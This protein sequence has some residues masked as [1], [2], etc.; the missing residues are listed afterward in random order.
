MLTTSSPHNPQANGQAESGVAIAERILRQNDPVKALMVYRATP[1]VSTGHSPS[2]LMM[3][4]EMSTTLPILS[5][6]LAPHWPDRERLSENVKNTQMNYEKQYNRR[7]GVRPMPELMP[8]DRVRVKLD[9]ESKW[10]QPTT[11]VRQHETPRSYVVQSQSGR[12]YRRNRRHLQLLPKTNGSNSKDKASDS[13]ESQPAVP[14][15]TNVQPSIQP[16]P[17]RETPAST[18]STN[19]ESSMSQPVTTRSGRTVK[20]PGWQKDFAK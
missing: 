10:G 9:N 14:V 19:A 13:S 1:V 16:N 7:H 6:T 8:G 5:K 2:R 12:E 4:R 17:V 3:G 15:H 20:P 18:P 11:V